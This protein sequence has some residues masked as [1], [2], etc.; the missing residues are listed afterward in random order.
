MSARS[1]EAWVSFGKTN[2]RAKVGKELEMF[3]QR[4]QR[5]ALGLLIRRQRLPLWAAHRTEKNRVAFTANPQ[6]LRRERV[7]IH[8]DRH[9]AH[10]RLREIKVE[11]EFLGRRPSRTRRAS[12]ITSGPM[13]SPGSTAMRKFFIEAGNVGATPILPTRKRAR[14]AGISFGTSTRRKICAFS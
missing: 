14:Q 10:T 1:G 12:A 3:A 13:P 2:R 11:V 7:P 4:Q 6:R 5:R 8:V 9:P